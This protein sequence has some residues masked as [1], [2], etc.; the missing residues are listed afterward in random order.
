[1]P[2]SATGNKG[3]TRPVIYITAV[4]PLA[5]A[6]MATRHNCPRFHQI[7]GIVYPQYLQKISSVLSRVGNPK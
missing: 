4:L 1:M 5:D 6:F 2:E 7:P 3:K